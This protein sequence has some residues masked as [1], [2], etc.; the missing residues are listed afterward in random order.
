MKEDLLRLK[1]S[2]DTN[3]RYSQYIGGEGS[4]FDSLS[5]EQ[6]VS[7]DDS[8]EAVCYIEN[9]MKTAV[10]NLSSNNFL[11][12]KFS[13]SPVFSIFVDDA[14]IDENGEIID[15]ERG[16]IKDFVCIIFNPLKVYNCGCP[17][18][19]VGEFDYENMPIFLTKFS[20][21]V[22]K[23]NEYGYELD[24]IYSFNDI[25]KRISCD[26]SAIGEISVVFDKKNVVQK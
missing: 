21:F 22:L 5:I 10:C 2:F 17:V 18:E 3:K 6:I 4:L 13:V 26:E 8:L 11:Y 19:H 23:L 7:R 20:D 12:D 14:A 24:M 15:Y 16:I 9:L 1:S 25:C